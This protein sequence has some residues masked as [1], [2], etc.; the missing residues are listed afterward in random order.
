MLSKNEKEYEARIN[1]ITGSSQKIGELME[2]L[3]EEI[4]ESTRKACNMLIKLEYPQFNST[5]NLKFSE[6]LKYEE[7]DVIEGTGIIKD[8][9][10]MEGIALIDYTL[11]HGLEWKLRVV[12]DEGWIGMGLISDSQARKA[13]FTTKCEGSYLVDLCMIDS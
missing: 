4:M 9:S 8:Y 7:M 10:D 3:T 5:Q 2:N 11:E 12:S 13:N 6:S 1:D